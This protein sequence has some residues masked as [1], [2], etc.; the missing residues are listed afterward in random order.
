MP[1]M[2][3]LL[4]IT[5]GAASAE[6]DSYDKRRLGVMMQCEIGWLNGLRQKETP[7]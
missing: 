4:P 7:Q 5:L 3:I 6:K 1:V 2:L